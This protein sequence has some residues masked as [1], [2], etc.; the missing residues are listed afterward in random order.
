MAKKKRGPRCRHPKATLATYK[1][2]YGSLHWC[3]KC[4]A[5]RRV[6]RNGNTS[7]LAPTHAPYRQEGNGR[8]RRRAACADGRIV[9]MPGGPERWRVLGARKSDGYLLVVKIDDPER[10]VCHVAPQ[11][12]RTAAENE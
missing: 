3:M 6:F 1:M 12:V 9:T 2:S 8:L 4:G 10:R 5:A 11:Y 7:W